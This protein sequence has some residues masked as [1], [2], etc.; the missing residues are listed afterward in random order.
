MTGR[1]PGPLISTLRRT[2]LAIL[3]GDRSC[4]TRTNSHT[5]AFP[6]TKPDRRE[7]KSKNRGLEML[8]PGRRS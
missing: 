1:P 4:L 8:K 3:V 7:E 2:N 5:R 6:V